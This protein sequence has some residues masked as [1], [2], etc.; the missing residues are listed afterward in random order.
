VCARVCACVGVCAFVQGLQRE[1]E[2]EALQRGGE[3]R[4]SH[5]MQKSTYTAQQWLAAVE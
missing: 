2:E 4:S 1:E 3:P 5:T